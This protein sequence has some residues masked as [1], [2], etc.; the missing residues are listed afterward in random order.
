[1]TEQLLGVVQK[2][3]LLSHFGLRF[4]K[5]RFVYNRI[6]TVRRYG[7][8]ISYELFSNYHKELKTFL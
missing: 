8:S 5:R 7:L 2:V 4:T 1:M 3:A 6:A